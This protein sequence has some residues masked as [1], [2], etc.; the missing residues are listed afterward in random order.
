MKGGFV[1][2]LI[3]I[4]ERRNAAQFAEFAVLTLHHPEGTEMIGDG[5]NLLSDASLSCDQLSPLSTTFWTLALALQRCRDHHG[6]CFHF[7]GCRVIVAPA[8]LPF[9]CVLTRNI[10]SNGSRLCIG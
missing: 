4:R 2:A 6:C 9:C 8:P 5:L 1:G 10:K 7:G 3:T